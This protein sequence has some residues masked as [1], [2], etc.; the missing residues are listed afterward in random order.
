MSQGQNQ[1]HVTGISGSAAYQHDMITIS[2]PITE[3]VI[4]PMQRECL[5]RACFRL[6]FEQLYVFAIS[7]FFEIFFRDETKGGGIH[8]VTQSRRSRSVVK[9]MTEM[10]IGMFTPDFRS[11]REK[12]PVF[13][14]DNVAGFERSGICLLYTSDAAD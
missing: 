3:P 13:F 4:C 9:D 6:L 7:F 8:A 1:P 2:V 10:G 11:Y 12:P 5:V 14:F